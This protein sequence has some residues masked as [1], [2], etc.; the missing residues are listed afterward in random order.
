MLQQQRKSFATLHARGLAGLLDSP[1][2]RQCQAPLAMLGDSAHSRQHQSPVSWTRR[3]PDSSRRHSPRSGTHRSP[4]SKTFH[5]PSLRTRHARRQRQ[6]SAAMPGDLTRS[7]TRYTGDFT[8]SRTRHARGLAVLED[9]PPSWA[10]HARSP[11]S[12]IRSTTSASWHSGR[13]RQWRRQRHQPRPLLSS[14]YFD[15]T[16]S[17]DD[18][19]GMPTRL[20]ESLAS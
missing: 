16:P 18:V 20:D 17:D 13:S 5:S 15:S 4:V 11:A 2:S 19:P 9:S 1:H 3:A 14:F 12:P 8:R 10:H 6:A 7:W